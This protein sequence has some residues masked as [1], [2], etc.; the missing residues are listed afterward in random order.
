MNYNFLSSPIP[1]QLANLTSLSII[2]LS[3]CGLQ[4]SVP[5]LPQLQK[6]DVS[7][8]F[9]LRF[10][11]P[12]MF[13]NRWPKLKILDISD[14]E[15]TGS[16]SFL[17]SISNAPMLVSLSASMSSIQG[18]LPP[19]IYNLSRLQYLDLSYNNITSFI[20]SSISNLKNLHFLDL[21]GNNFQGPIQSSICEIVSLRRLVLE[22]NNIT[23]ILP[24][25][26]TM[27][28]NLV[29][30]RVSKNS[31]E[32]NVSLIS[33][34]N[35][36]HLSTLDL[37]SNRLTIDTNENLHLDASK[38]K[39]EILALGSCNLKVFLTF[40]C[41]LTQLK[42]LNLSHNNLTGVIP[43][44]I[45]KLEN[46]VYLDLSNNKLHSPLP[47]PPL[48]VSSFDLPHNKLEGNNS[49]EGVIPIGLGSLNSLK[50]LSLRSN[51]FNGS[52]PKEITDL[53]ELQILDLSIN[54]LS[55]PIPVSLGKLKLV[56][57]PS[58][59][60]VQRNSIGVQ[61][62]LVI[63]GTMRQFEIMYDYSSGID[64]SCNVLDG[65]IPEEIG[66][67]NGLVM[68]NLSHNHFSSNIPASV[69]NMS[70]LESLD[71]S[72]NKLDGHIPQENFV[73]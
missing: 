27:L 5:Y 50:I 3:I 36:F 47:L 61:F 26:I 24:S 55:G 66:L 10:D 31:I 6:L 4:G 12:N 59:G 67:L 71:L 53:Y 34:I 43:P 15:V 42:V 73:V 49:F 23:G 54:N 11:L 46:L 7:G 41:I 9:G 56:S 29:E 39:L 64:L 62:Q 40:I 44:C 63:K 1:A 68:L 28:T 60:S 69:G 57:N 21:S 51:K 65:K 13:E 30:F 25:C 18:S 2:E 37:T 48:S 32:V 35:K 70:S 38:P 20:H 14:N 22:N 45:F 72:F 58:P 52:I 16:R 17:S 19:S 33:L 8:N